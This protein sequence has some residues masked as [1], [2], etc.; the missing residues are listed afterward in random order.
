MGVAGRVTVGPPGVTVATAVAGVA[1]GISVVGMTIV[2]SPNWVGVAGRLVAG[3]AA[4][5]ATRAKNPAQ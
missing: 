1:E 5:G 4:L 2:V 3:L